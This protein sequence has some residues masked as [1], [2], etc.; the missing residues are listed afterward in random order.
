MDSGVTIERLREAARALKSGD[1]RT[2]LRAIQAAQDALDAAKAHELAV[3]QESKDYEL[4][5]ASSVT[6]WAR[7]ELRLDAKASKAL[8]RAAVTMRDLPAVGQAAAEGRIRLD[9]VVV[10]GYGLKHIGAEV[11][12]Q[13]EAWLLE[14]AVKHEPAGLRQVMRDLRE[15]IYPDELDQAW[16]DGMDRHDIHVN[17]VPD[18]W[19]VNG[20][21]DITT[22][23]KFRQVLD[24]L[25]APRDADDQRPGS[26]RRVEAFDRML[27]TVLESGLP[28]DQGIRPQLSII[29]DTHGPSARL[30][31]FGSIGPKLL[32]YLTCLSDLTTITT[33][34][35][36]PQATVL[37]V[38]RTRRHANRQQRRAII[39]RQGGEC[40]APGCHHT[41]LEIHHVTWWSHGGRTDLDQMIGL[42]VRCHHLVHRERLNIERHPER[43]RLH[44]PTRHTHRPPTPTTHH[45]P[46][47]TSKQTYQPASST[48]DVSRDAVTSS[49]PLDATA[50][51]S[52]GQR[53]STRAIPSSGR[54]AC[55]C[56]PCPVRETCG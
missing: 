32:D 36:G 9:H 54:R 37:N 5:G 38:G 14:V 16:I 26:A 3:L 45:L 34:G 18:G 22:G 1:S 19:H 33:D 35:N 47:T 53:R 56:M 21:L 41:H 10:F 24:T 7:N 29:V 55:P 13:S 4:D 52:P 50:R 2:K 27:T 20:F 6:T 49:T 28:S 25:G 43:I 40:A 23:A 39:T 51:R 17:P 31:G 11:V 30:A 44:H 15:A 48:T 46:A 42:C 12:S 8:V